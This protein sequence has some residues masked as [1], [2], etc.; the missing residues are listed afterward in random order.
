MRCRTRRGGLCLLGSLLREIRDGG[1]R[2]FLFDTFGVVRFL[3]SPLLF[4]VEG[5][6]DADTLGACG[7]LRSVPGL[8][9][10]LD[11]R[12]R[13]W[14]PRAA[15]DPRRHHLERTLADHQ[16]VPRSVSLS[17]LASVLVTELTKNHV[18][19]LSTTELFN[20][21]F[22]LYVDGPRRLYNY[23]GMTLLNNDFGSLKQAD[24]SRYNVNT[25]PGQLVRGIGNG[26]FRMPLRAPGKLVQLGA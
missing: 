1:R 3:L 21:P 15:Q 18:L 7:S 13:R 10:Q 8:H 6:G 19:G 11:P 26:L 2:C 16:E 20:C 25:V 12:A 9:G 22:P 23:L 17:H 14:R 5:L 4:S 24:R